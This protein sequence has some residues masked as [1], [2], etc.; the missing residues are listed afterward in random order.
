MWTVTARPLD[1]ANTG[2]ASQVYPNEI[3][4]FFRLVALGVRMTGPKIFQ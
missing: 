3:P 4:G 2:A 1:S